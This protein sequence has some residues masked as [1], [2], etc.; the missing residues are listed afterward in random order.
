[1]GDLLKSVV[2]APLPNVLILGGLIFLGLAVVGKIRGKIDL[3]RWPRIGSAALAVILLATGLGVQHVTGLK[4]APVSP[5]LSEPIML[6]PAEGAVLDNLPRH[7]TLR[8]TTVLGAATYTVKVESC[9]PSGCQDGTARTLKLATGLTSTSYTFEFVGAGPGR[10]RVWAVRAD[11][12][13]GPKPR[14]RDFRYAR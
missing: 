9:E 2:S 4:P 6:S 12:Q 3:G 13:E 10:W 14:F 7:T 8:W 11:G 1:M 5:Q